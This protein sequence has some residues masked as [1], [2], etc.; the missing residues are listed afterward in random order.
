MSQGTAW[1][2]L[3]GQPVVPTELTLKRIG[4]WAGVPLKRVRALAGRSVGEEQPFILPEEFDQLPYPAREAL[5]QVGWV[6]L[7][8][9]GQ[10]VTR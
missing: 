6:M 3:T 10:R 1:R 8:L 5:E 7:G 4:R 9:R 2:L